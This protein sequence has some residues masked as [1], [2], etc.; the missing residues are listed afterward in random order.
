LERFE[1]RT[2]PAN[3]TAA[4]VSELIAHI[5][6]A[7]LTPETDTIALMSNHTYTLT[8]VN[9]TTHGPTGLP[10]IQSN[11][12]LLG[13]GATIAR[14]SADTTPAFRLL[15][16]AAGAS[17]SILNATLTGGLVDADAANVFTVSRGGA[18]YSAGQLILNGV[19]V[20]KNAAKGGMG[21]QS[22]GGPVPGGT[23]AGGGVYSTGNLTMLN[24]TI[25]NNDAVGGKGVKGTILAFDMGFAVP[26]GAGGD[27]LGGGVY[28]SN[29][30]VTIS[31]CKFTANSAHGGKGGKGVTIP[32]SG[33]P[34]N[35]NPTAGGNGGNA[36]GGGFHVASGSVTLHGVRVTRN[37]ANHG[38]AGLGGTEGPFQAP[39]GVAGE[40]LGG[41]IYIGPAAWV[42]LDAFS[43]DHV[44]NNSGSTTAPNIF[45]DYELIP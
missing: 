16:V 13:N 7:N 3:F 14:K 32:G 27:A 17:L 43:L 36:F 31:N 25:R 2:V 22:W 44:R 24:C 18:I 34:N 41:G 45:G 20:E 37:S 33:G 19:T 28:A 40:G 29:G 21:F 1:D 39:N 12:T 38:E 6:A 5:N 26:G 23:A 35:Q 11:I 9:N 4:N 15:D 30:I 10:T 8:T 42:S